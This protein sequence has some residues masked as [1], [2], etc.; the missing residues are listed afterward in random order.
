M[1]IYVCVCMFCK[2]V[3]V[4]LNGLHWGNTNQLGNLEAPGGNKIVRSY[5]FK[6]KFEIKWCQNLVNTGLLK[7][8]E[9]EVGVRQSFARRA[10][11]CELLLLFLNGALPL[12]SR[13]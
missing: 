4:G 9:V 3:G 5:F 2:N 12:C 10:L 8:H 13:Q 1:G 6:N 11:A 7:P